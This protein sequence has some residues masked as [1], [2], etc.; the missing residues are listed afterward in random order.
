MYI[1]ILGPVV[2]GLPVVQL[3]VYNLCACAPLTRKGPLSRVTGHER[4]MDSTATA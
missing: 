3:A 4:L 1:D 2:G